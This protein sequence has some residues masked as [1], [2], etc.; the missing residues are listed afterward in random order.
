[1]IQSLLV[2]L[3]M[4]GAT[5]AVVFWIGWHAPQ[6]A[7]EET[8]GEAASGERPP[9]A[10]SESAVES[11]PVPVAAPASAGPPAPAGPR[12]VA[13]ADAVQPGP[14]KVLDLNRASLDDIEALPGIGPVLAQRVIDYRASAGKFKSVEELR[15]VK[16]IGAKKLERLRPFVAV[17]TP[18]AS[19]RTEKQ[20]S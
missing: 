18:D 1:M 5:L 4:L 15:Q 7:R 6:A 20:P 2:K 17:G 11:A 9:A 16:G 13:Q 19:R 14:S 8:A 3:A 10:R 12:K